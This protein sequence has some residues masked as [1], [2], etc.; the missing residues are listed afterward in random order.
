MF[1]DRTSWFD[2]RTIASLCQVTTRP[3]GTRNLGTLL[4][5]PWLELN[6]RLHG[7]VA[8]QGFADVRPALSAVFQHVRDDG[9][10]V[11]EIARRA[12]LTKQTV[13]Y[14]VDE[15]E[16]LGYVERVAD[17]DDGRAKLVRPT[18]RGHAAV[19]EARQAAAA[20]ERDWAVLLG[21][22]RMAQLRAGLEAL[23]DALWPP[24]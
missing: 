10:R 4:R 18:P 6:A 15:L 22:E 23:H 11:T 7:A 17:P 16:R 5:D 19:A 24:A 1:D 13:V 20:I 2:H 12:Q 8:E 9:S 21:E 14:L 3:L